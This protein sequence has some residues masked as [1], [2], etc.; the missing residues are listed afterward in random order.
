MSTEKNTIIQS[1]IDVDL[2]DIKNISK[3]IEDYTVDY[4][5]E[6]NAFYFYRDF[7]RNGYTEAMG[8][9]PTDGLKG[10]YLNNSYYRVFGDKDICDLL[11]DMRYI[12][13]MLIN[14]SRFR[15]V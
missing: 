9:I 3:I 11:R 14:N 12:E 10:L 2:M 15:R 13:Q 1:C 6:P 7:M 8:N 5:D 4:D